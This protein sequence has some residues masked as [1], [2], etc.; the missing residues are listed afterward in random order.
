MYVDEI[1]P[2]AGDAGML[3]STPATLQIVTCVLYGVPVGT[4]TLTVIDVLVLEFRVIVG[5]IGVTL[6]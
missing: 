1:W 4:E 2:T 6:R 3:V 5:A